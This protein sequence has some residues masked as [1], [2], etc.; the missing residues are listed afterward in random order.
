MWPT[1]I[2]RSARP[3][4]SRVA[5]S[6][7]TIRSS[8]GPWGS[9]PSP[10]RAARLMAAGVDPAIHTGGRGLCAGRGAGAEARRDLLLLERGDEFRD[11]RPDITA[12]V[13]VVGPEELE[14]LRDVTRADAADRTAT[15]QVVERGE[16][17]GRD[18]GVPVGEDVHM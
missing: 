10:S 6:N 3:A 17:L 2:G 1:A 4:A 16:R 18:H 9:Q 8:D 15:R 14:L 5:S 11:Q 12:A 7:A 13:L